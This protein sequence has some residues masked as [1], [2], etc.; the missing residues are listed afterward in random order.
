MIKSF[1]CRWMLS[2]ALLFFQTVLRKVFGVR[3]PTQSRVGTTTSYMRPGYSVIFRQ[4]GHDISIF[5]NRLL[6]LSVVSFSYL[7]CRTA[8]EN[9]LRTHASS[10]SRC[11]DN[12]QEYARPGSA[13]RR[14]ADA[15][16]HGT[17]GQ[18][19]VQNLGNRLFAFCVSHS[20]LLWEIFGTAAFFCS[21]SINMGVRCWFYGRRGYAAFVTR[22]TVGSAIVLCEI[23]MSLDLKK[24]TS[25]AG[26]YREMRNTQSKR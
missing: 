21:M 18:R 22:R 3:R 20:C 7:L 10:P 24:T 14:R 25:L 1:S 12:L 23:Y 11:E 17:T 16:D 15:V 2:G 5:A 13:G 4:L 9:L 6:L 19:E 26:V 8:G